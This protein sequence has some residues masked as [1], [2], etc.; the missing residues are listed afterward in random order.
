MSAL[1]RIPYFCTEFNIMSSN[2]ENLS[3][4]FCGREKKDTNVLIAG[5]DGHICD[6]CIR[7]A[8]GI[9]VEELDTQERKELSRSMRLIKPKEIKQ[10]LDQ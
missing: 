5:I 3:C 4:S 6:H 1:E 7:Q 2:K 8:Y 9:V 10:F